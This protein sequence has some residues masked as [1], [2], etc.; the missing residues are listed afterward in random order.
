MIAL[1]N[2]VAQAES[3]E[4]VLAVVADAQ[5]LAALQQDDALIRLKAVEQLTGNLQPVV[6]NA[7]ADCAGRVARRLRKATRWCTSAR[8]RPLPVSKQEAEFYSSA[9]TIFLA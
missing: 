1:L 4:R 5:A 9:E 6:L 7:P 3:S 8:K 2:Q